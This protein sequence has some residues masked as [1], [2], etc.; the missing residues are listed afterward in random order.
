MLSEVLLAG[1]S[2][3]REVRRPGLSV[4][5]LFPCPHALYRK[6]MGGDSREVT[7]QV[8]MLMEDGHWQEEQT[9][10]RLSSLG[11]VVEDRQREVEVGEAKIP[12]HIDGIIKLGK[13]RLFEHKAMSSDR[14]LYLKQRKL[15]GFPRMK[16][17]VQAYMLGLRDQ[18]LPIDETIFFAKHK[19]SCEPFDFIEKFDVTFISVVVGWVDAII[20]GG[21][22]PKP[23][24][25]SSC[26]HCNFNCFGEIIDMSRVAS[27]SAPEMAEKWR[28]GKQLQ[29][30][31]KMLEEEARS[32]FLEQIGSRDVLSVE[33]L[34]V[35]KVLQHRFNISKQRVFEEFGAE[36]LLK[37]GEEKEI[38]TYR[39]R[40][41]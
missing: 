20:L 31:G 1:K 29:N 25:T 5:G 38:V 7:P 16:V 4:S 36:G 33:G 37:V 34:E 11:V 40:E 39:I 8:E 30:V 32:F 18:G 19:D 9:I 41:V 3:Q 14:F 26:V 13:S 6:Y 10:Q 28:R 24:Q 21:W 23:E 27:L 17:Q 15:D 12:G 35:K 2:K 22:E